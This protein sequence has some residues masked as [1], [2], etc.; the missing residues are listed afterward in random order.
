MSFIDLIGGPGEPISR[1]I[2][3]L[4]T[5]AQMAV[6]CLCRFWS[7]STLYQLLL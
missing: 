6:R 2:V 3:F 4:S 7:S 5:T 1:C